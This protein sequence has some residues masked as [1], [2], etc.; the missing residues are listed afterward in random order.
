MSRLHVV[1][2]LLLL[3]VLP[4]VAQAFSY[5]AYT[6]TGVHLSHNESSSPLNSSS[7]TGDARP[8]N[9]SPNQYRMSVVTWNLAEKSPS[10][11]DY[12]FLKELQ[13]ESDFIVLGVQ[14]LEDIKP[15]RH[16]GTS[17]YYSFKSNHSHQAAQPIV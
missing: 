7:V 16:E 5:K 10:Q 9:L 3:L 17:L 4:Q 15:R 6:S 2:L 1:V 11:R 14:E 13:L 12:S 8:N